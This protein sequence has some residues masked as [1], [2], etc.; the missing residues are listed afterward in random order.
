M[1][2]KKM[3]KSIIYIFISL[4]ITSLLLFGCGKE[5]VS[6]EINIDTLKNLEYKIEV[7][8]NGTAKLK[9]GSFS[10]EAAPGSVSKTEVKLTENVASGDL[11]NNNTL[12]AAV[13]L[14]A[15]GGGSGSFYYLDAV[16]NNG[17]KLESIN[18]VFLGDRIKIVNMTIDK[19]TITVNFLDRK[20]DQAMAEE[21]TVEVIKRFKVE[22]NNL[23]EI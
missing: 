16:I 2:S 3:K 6:S 18:S 15:S 20:P 13:I 21:P 5:K 7:T 11:D 10:E 4:V 12:D 8:S 9:D 14:W 1:G 19:G 22:G 17:D 23:V